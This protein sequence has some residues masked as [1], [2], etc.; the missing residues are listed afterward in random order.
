MYRWMM[1]GVFTTRFGA[2]RKRCR[3]SKVQPH[4]L[5]KSIASFFF[6]LLPPDGTKP[7]AKPKV[8]ALTNGSGNQDKADHSFE[9]QGQIATFC[10]YR[11]TSA[12]PAPR[13]QCSKSSTNTILHHF[14]PVNDNSMIERLVLLCEIIEP[15]QSSRARWLF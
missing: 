9:L 15:I 6:H 12:S 14:R 1:L 13:F 4:K 7:K 10:Q 3:N 11:I 8:K 5:Q 2:E